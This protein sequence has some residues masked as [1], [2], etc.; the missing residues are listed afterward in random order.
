MH[1]SKAH[2]EHLEG[3]VDGVDL[4]HIGAAPVLNGLVADTRAIS[5][6]AYPDPL[7]VHLL[8]ETP[9][10]GMDTLRDTQRT[11]ATHHS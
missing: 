7:V 5:E 9:H 11:E 3:R 1:G 8:V 4:R 6:I 10:Q 2:A